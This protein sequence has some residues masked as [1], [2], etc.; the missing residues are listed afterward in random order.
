MAQMKA[1]REYRDRERVEVAVLDALV[2]RTDGGMTVFELRAAV[3][4]EIDELES[5][6]ADLKADGLIV[7]E[8]NGGRAV[9]KP[10]ERVVPDENEPEESDESFIGWIRRK[11]PF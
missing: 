4:I 10:A 7:V 8:T 1:K 5:A 3:E 9:I 6:L 2:N 11:L